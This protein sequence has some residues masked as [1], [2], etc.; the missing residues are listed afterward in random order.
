MGTAIAHRH[1]DISFLQAQLGFIHFF[2]SPHDHVPAGQIGGYTVPDKDD[3]GI[4]VADNLRH[5][6]IDKTNDGKGG[7]G[8]LAHRTDGKRS[9]DGLD[10]LFQRQALGN[11]GRNDAGSKN[12]EDISFYPAAQAVGQHQHRGILSLSYRFHMVAAQFLT[13]MVDAIV[14]NLYTQVIH[15]I[16]NLSIYTG[17]FW[18]QRPFRPA[19]KL[20][21][22]QCASAWP[23]HHPQSRQSA[24]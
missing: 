2:I 19:G 6:I 10:T 5:L 14:A 7:I 1:Q 4:I 13:H 17:Q 15:R 18:S 20:F 16:P 23:P 12:R 8:H 24:G 3:R 22:A 11:H 21:P 9:R